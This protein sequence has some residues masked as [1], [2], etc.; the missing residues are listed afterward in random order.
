MATDVLKGHEVL[1]AFISEYLDD[2]GDIIN[3]NPVSGGCINTCLKLDTQSSSYFVKYNSA[4]AYP[5]M[6]AAEVLGLKL[7]RNTQAIGIPNVVIQYAFQATD[8]L[9]LDWIDPAIEAP[10]YWEQFGHQLAELHTHTSPT[11]GLAHNNYI[12][13]LP[14]INTPNQ[15]G[16]QFFI[17]NRLQP[18]LQLAIDKRQLPSNA[19][20]EFETL[21]QKLPSI[22]PNAP[23]ALLH[24][25]LWEGN[26]LT[27]PDGR[28]WLVDPS[29]QYG[30]REAEIAYTQL[31]GPFNY[32][33]YDAYN[34]AFP[35]SPGFLARADVYNLYPLLVHVNLFGGNYANRVMAA[36][37]KYL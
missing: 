11:F 28:A 8:F 9:V 18:Q 4:N 16:I 27:G 14:Q 26:Y 7:L 33:F 37:Q 3:A 31:F 22:L 29:V 10:D 5:G 17:E 20:S 13:S 1:R 6:M 21:Y 35:L 24:G 25:D 15:N 12:G 19:V 34:E 36:L 23:A 2:I 30:F 32:R